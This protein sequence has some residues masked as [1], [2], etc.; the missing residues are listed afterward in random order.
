MVYLGIDF[1][2][3]YTK[4]AIYDT[5]SNEARLKLVELNSTSGDFGFGS[6]SY[7][8]PTCV[9]YTTKE[10]KF[11][12]GENAIN[13]RLYPEG[14]FFENFKP[15]LDGEN[16]YIHRSPDITYEAAVA[17]VLA[18]I[19][20]KTKQQP[21]DRVVITVPASTIPDG[22]RWNLMKRAA[23]SVGFHNVDIISEPEAAGYCLI[24]EKLKNRKNGELF[25]IYDFGGGTFD[26]TLI[27]VEDEQIFVV[28]ES[29][30]TDSQQRWGGIYI[31]S[32]IRKHYI[33]NSY[34]ANRYV[35]EL[36]SRSLSRVEEL[37]REKH[38]RMEPERAKKDL[39]NGRKERFVNSFGDYFLSKNSF[40]EMTQEM[41]DNTINKS[42]DLI[43]AI[44]EKDESITLNRIKTIFLVGGSSRMSLVKK[45]WEEKKKIYSYEY[46]IEETEI[47]VV[48][49]G[50]ALYHFYHITPQRLVEMGC[51]KAKCQDYKLA[52]LYF[53]NA[54]SPEGKYYL[55]ILYYS[56]TLTHGKA[57][58]KKALHLFNQSFT[59]QA[60][61]MLALMTFLGTGV[62]KNDS[63]VIEYL[64]GVPKTPIAECLDRSASGKGTIS[65]FDKIYSFNPLTVL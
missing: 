59:P 28:D 7:A 12:V 50:A 13:H 1:G 52:S 11:Y 2:T 31:D 40:E 20:E 18:H 29:V 39:S 19:C 10:K 48:A 5:D 49:K 58:Y 33:N 16:Q 46:N 37:Q 22:L 54:N 15:E 62:K 51:Q 24:G 65:D 61:E 64:K 4:A 21:F 47:E 17:A 32:I 25:L 42:I 44:H 45:M 57:A 14:Y 30:G 60:K 3:A 41:V 63:A 26:T 53:N 6:N 34:Q 38:L 23:Y 36:A 56:G 9:Y 43:S 55:G 35:K 8:M 27:T